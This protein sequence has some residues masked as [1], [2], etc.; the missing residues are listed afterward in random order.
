VT[1][2]LG[3]VFHDASGIPFT[4]LHPAGGVG[5]RTIALPF[6]VAFVDFGYGANGTAVFSG[7]NY[8]F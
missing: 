5:F 7:I 2:D 4:H 1:V 6:V 8:P 3:R